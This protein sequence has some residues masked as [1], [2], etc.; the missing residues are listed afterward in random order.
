MKILNSFK[1]EK[2]SSYEMVGLKSDEITF[3]EFV[4]KPAAILC[5]FDSSGEYEF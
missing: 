5:K 2:M 4:R 1:E 3:F